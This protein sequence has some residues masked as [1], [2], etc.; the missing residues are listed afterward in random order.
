M[1]YIYV[2]KQGAAISL[3]K[4]RFQVKYKNE[5]LQS[6][7]I[8]TVDGLEIFGNIQLTT[9]TFQECLKRGIAVIFYSTTG[10]YYGKLM[11]TTN[12][13]VARQRK[14]AALMDDWKLEMSK[15]LIKAKINNQLVV[16]S[17]YQRNVDCAIEQEKTLMRVMRAKVPIAESVEQLMGFEGVAARA[18]FKALGQMIV[19]EFRFERRSKRPPEDE[20]NSVISLGYSLFLNEIYGKLES[21]G[22]NPFFG[23]LHQDREN[24]PTLASDL[25]EEWR[26]VLVDSAA[27]GMI[28][29]SELVKENFYRREGQPGIFLTD[30]GLRICLQKYEKRMETVNSYLPE[31]VQ[32]ITFRQAIGIQVER[33][34]KAI[35]TGDTAEYEP[36]TIR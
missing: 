21:R 20:F 29:G 25:L 10:N 34:I 22:L 13:N 2:C 14:Q 1:A 6:I 19:P 15:K 28:N 23:I 18:Y 9:Q 30:E 17:R 32:P 26:A 11:S 3:Q 35:E 24:H 33:L 7:P 31:L 16:L 36:L 5:L 8:E 12:V 4:N 27:L